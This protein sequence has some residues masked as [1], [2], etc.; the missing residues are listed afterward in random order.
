MSNPQILYQDL[1]SMNPISLYDNT[2]YPLSNLKT[3]EPTEIFK[4]SSLE[5]QILDFEFTITANRNTI[6]IINHNLNSLVAAP[7]PGTHYITIESSTESTFAQTTTLLEEHPPNNNSLWCKTFNATSERFF[8]ISLIGGAPLLAQQ[9]YFGNVFIGKSIEFNSPQDY[10]FTND[11]EY[12]TYSFITLNGSRKSS[13]II[14][15]SRTISLNFRLQNEAIRTLL[16]QFLQTIRGSYRPFVFID[17]DGV[18]HYVNLVD[19]NFDITT[20]NY[21]RHDF[22]L[23]MKEHNSK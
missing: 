8:R 18:A 9:P 6:A 23:N 22:Q 21:Q 3:Y 7:D 15:P 14:G 11:D 2:S 12:E 13:Q 16:I 10:S 4:S 20:M 17:S 5:E 19:D 1:S